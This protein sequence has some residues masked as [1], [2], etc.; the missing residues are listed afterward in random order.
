M[1]QKY[2]SEYTL[3]Y[4]GYVCDFMVKF[5]HM[6]SCYDYWLFDAQTDHYTYCM[7]NIKTFVSFLFSY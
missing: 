6:K 2:S 7:T 3:V 5:I 4:G 1:T